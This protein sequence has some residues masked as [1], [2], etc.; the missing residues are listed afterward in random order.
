MNTPNTRSSVSSNQTFPNQYKS[1][2]ATQIVTCKAHF[3]NCA[4]FTSQL[5]STSASTTTRCSHRDG[6][7]FTSSPSDCIV[8]PDILPSASLLISG[9]SRSARGAKSA[10]GWRISSLLPATR[11]GYRTR[12]STSRTSSCV[13]APVGG[14]ARREDECEASLG[15]ALADHR[16]ICVAHCLLEVGLAVTSQQEQRPAARVCGQCGGVGERD[17]SCDVIRAAKFFLLCSMASPLSP[18]AC[19]KSCIIESICSSPDLRR[20]SASDRA[21]WP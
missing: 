5:T 12:Q 17:E 18:C 3:T 11:M 15:C 13:G 20:R 16:A 8:S 19:A 7:A 10:T 9:C 6:N 1:T 2:D 21:L 4:T 14:Y